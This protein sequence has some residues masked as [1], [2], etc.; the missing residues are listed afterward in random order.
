ML[1]LVLFGDQYHAAG[2]QV[3]RDREVRQAERLPA[4]AHLRLALVGRRP[5]LDGHVHIV[6]ARFRLERPRE[7]PRVIRL[8]LD[9]DEIQ[10]LKTGWRQRVLVAALVGVR[11]R[12]VSRVGNAGVASGRDPRLRRRRR[13]LLHHPQHH[14][15]GRA[16]SP[17]GVDQRR[18]RHVG[19]SDP[20]PEAV[21]VA[22][23][24]RQVGL[25]VLSH[26]T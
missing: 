14:R 26:F 10:I 5:L 21:I 8:R 11:S 17:A 12:P 6:V 25:D 4:H 13:A 7:L 23:A 3:A 16:R 1:Q 19:R 9:V 20:G 2:R 24:H 15:H 18:E 22:N